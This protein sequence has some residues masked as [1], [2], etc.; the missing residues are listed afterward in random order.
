MNFKLLF[1]VIFM[2]FGI[3]SYAVETKKL[4]LCPNSPNCVSSQAI[5]KE[6]FIEPFKIIGAINDA[7]LA[8]KNALLAQERTV[9]TQETENTLHA[10]ATSLIFRF[11]D[12]V[13]IILDSQARL[14]HIRSASRIGYGD[15]GVNRKRVEALRFKL[16]S[17]GVIE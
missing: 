15:F 17:A 8:L 12:D 4:A 10:E 6:H 11:V 3:N 13:D 9:I 5:D 1:Y 14:F 7:S 2:T 16:Q